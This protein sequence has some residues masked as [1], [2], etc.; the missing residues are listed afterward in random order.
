M[1]R[2]IYI[3]RN[4]RKSA[5]DFQVKPYMTI[6][7]YYPEVRASFKL[8]VSAYMYIHNKLTYPVEYVTML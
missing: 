6:V 7:C 2:P 5:G 8:V 3:W 1:L 4:H